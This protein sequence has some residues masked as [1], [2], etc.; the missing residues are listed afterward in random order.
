MLTLEL[1]VGL[2][3]SGKSTYARNLLQQGRPGAL[4]RVNRDDIRVS[5]F[6]GRVF[7]RDVEDKVS[8]VQRSAV[9]ELL[10]VGVSVIVDDPNLDPRHRRRLTDIA[11]T[12][13]AMVQLV[14]F[15]NVPLEVCLERNR[16]RPEAETVPEAVI[17]AMHEKWIQGLQWRG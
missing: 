9:V 4:A 8:I 3:A 13:G 6:G 14:P 2:P 17:R 5:V 7:G 10:R 16:R 15:I 1:T 11:S 12:Y